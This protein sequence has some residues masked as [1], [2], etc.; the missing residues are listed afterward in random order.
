MSWCTFAGYRTY[1]TVHTVIA[2]KANKK[3]MFSKYCW[4]RKG[5]LSRDF[6]PFFIGKKTLNRQKRFLNFFRFAKNNQ[7]KNVFGCVNKLTNPIAII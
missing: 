7:A 5:T 6:R 2:L 1:C 4:T 3:K